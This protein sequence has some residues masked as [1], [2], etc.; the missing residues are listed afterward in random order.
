MET[1]AQEYNILLDKVTYENGETTFSSVLCQPEGDGKYPAIITL[2]GIFGLQE[3]DARFPARLAADGYVV[4]AHGWQSREKDPSDSDIIKGIESAIQFLKQ[5]EKVD[6]ERVGLIGVCRGGSITMVAGAHI[7]ELKA[8]ISFYG[9][10]YYPV[11]NYKKPASPM[12]LIDKIQ[13]SI[14]LIHGEADTIF[15]V[16]ESIDYCKTLEERGKIHECKFYPGA[17]HGFFLQGHRNYFPEA[18]ED[19]WV[20]LK[21]FL[22]SILSV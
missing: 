12:D 21:N 3:M 8:L 18:S 22:R 13:A 9:Q 10:A 6:S 15:S 17:E 1:L 7:P 5:N 20:V 2:H 11:L 4:L 19:A 16:Q 14:L